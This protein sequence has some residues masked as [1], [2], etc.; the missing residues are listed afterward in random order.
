MCVD[1]KVCSKQTTSSKALF[2]K[3]IINNALVLF[4]CGGARRHVFVIYCALHSRLKTLGSLRAPNF[5][6]KS[7]NRPGEKPHNGFW[8]RDVSF[9]LMRSG[10]FWAPSLPRP[11]CSSYKVD[12]SHALA[13]G[14]KSKEVRARMDATGTSERVSR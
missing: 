1:S 6:L 4:L 8:R 10:R 12:R 7:L 11:L 3:A 14:A 2:I 9:A 5:P 13:R